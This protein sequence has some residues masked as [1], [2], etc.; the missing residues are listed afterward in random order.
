[1]TCEYHNTYELDA[2]RYVSAP[3]LTF[4]ACLKKTKVNLELLTNMNMLLMYENGIKGGICQAISL[5][6]K[7][8]NKYLKNYDKSISSSFLKYL[9]ANN[10]YGWAMCKKLPINE[11]K[12]GNVND[13]NESI[14]KSD[15]INSNYGMILNVDIEYP[16]KTA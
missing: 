3:N 5:Y 11:I 2:V 7:A 6:L 12:W 13:Y 4:Q 8:N 14:I 15:G 10:L 16:E 9:D 1:M